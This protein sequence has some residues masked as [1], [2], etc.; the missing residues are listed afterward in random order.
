MCYCFVRFALCYLFIWEQEEFGGS[1]QSW[2]NSD[3]QMLWIHSSHLENIHS[4]L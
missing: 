1:G 2:Q 4:E 3:Q